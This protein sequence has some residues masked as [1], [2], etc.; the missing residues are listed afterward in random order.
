MRRRNEYLGHLAEIPMFA[1]LAKKD[2]TTLARHA[3]EVELPEG[4]VLVEEGRRGREFFVIVDGKARVTRGGRKVADLGPGDYFGE[5]A[6]LDD[7]PRNATVT[8]L[9]P[10][11]VVVMERRA[12]SGVLDEIPS[13]AH[14][15]ATGLARRLREADSKAVN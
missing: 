10:L 6:L 1:A 7:A 13:I 2:L 15:L 14:K 5:L 3:D 11:T 8:A 9:T 4:R 12:F